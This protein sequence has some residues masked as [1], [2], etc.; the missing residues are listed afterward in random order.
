MAVST[1]I[2]IAI[3][4][5]SGAIGKRHT[6]EVLSNP[7]TN[8]VALVDP[9]P[10]GPEIAASHSIQYF[11]SVQELLSST[12]RKPAAAIVCTTNHTHVAVAKELATAGIHILLEKPLSSSTTEG[13]ELVRFV[14]EKDVRLLVG[15]HRRFNRHIIATKRAV[16]E[17]LLGQ[18]T[19]VSALW[20]NF[21]PADYFNS[22]PA[23]AW[24]SSKSRGGGVA[25]INLVHEIDLLQYF[26]GP[27]V[28]VHA[29][30][31][32]PRREKNEVPEAVEEHDRAEEGA[33]LI[34]CFRSGIVGTFL[35]SDHVVSPYNY[36]A[37]TR[38]NPIPL[39]DLADEQVDVYRILGTEGSLSVPDMVR[40]SYGAGRKK[41]WQT[42]LQKE[43]LP[44]DDDARPPFQ[45]Q[46]DHFVQ[47]IRENAQPRCSP[48]EALRAVL[49]CETISRAL[50]APGGTLE[51]PDVGI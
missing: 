4:G 40:W 30:K 36:E 15:H 7:S 43:R 12:N 41:G 24:R 16:E 5:F 9:S 31:T 10:A 33:A 13:L 47:V 22:D 35:L 2:D 32:V 14:R 11:S 8:L 20:A 49:V 25:V 27:I 26:F 3:V 6:A 23:L 29:E 48:T 44:V 37:T 38:E 17:G 34:L 51:V 46:L 18:I 42:E 45:R 1:P 21:K 50:D 19:A 28:R 39:A